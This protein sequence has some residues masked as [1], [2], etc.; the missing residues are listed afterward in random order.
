[1][2]NMINNKRNNR[3]NK[4]NKNKNEQQLGFPYFRNP[5]TTGFPPSMRFNHRYCETLSVAITGGVCQK[6]LFLTNGL[7]DPNYSGT[8]HQ[9]QYFDQ[10]APLYVYFLVTRSRIKVTASKYPVTTTVPIQLAVWVSEFTTTPFDISTNMENANPSGCRLIGDDNGTVTI[11]ETWNSGTWQG[12]PNVNPNLQGV[13]GTD[14]F[15]KNY[16]VIAANT[17]DLTASGVVYLSVEIEYDTLWT[18]RK[19]SPQS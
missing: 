15:T 7:N 6:Q 5:L 19:A 13:P 18:D 3:K 14:P 2:K 4:N 17:A 11:T 10:I 12:N 8:G 9:P 1:M 16:F